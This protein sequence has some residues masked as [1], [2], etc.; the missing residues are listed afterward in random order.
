LL[1]NWGSKTITYNGS[2]VVMFPS[3]YATNSWGSAYYGAPIRAWG[4]D[5]TFMQQGKQPPL[6][7]SLK[8]DAR[9]AWTYQ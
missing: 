5:A 6:F 7:P 1:E 4:F 3:T 2:I 9:S 8:A